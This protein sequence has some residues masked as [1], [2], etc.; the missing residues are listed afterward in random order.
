[1]SRR[2]AS[3]AGPAAIAAIVAISVW[4][5]RDH[6]R[7]DSFSSDEP[8]HLLAG[9]LQVFGHTAI[10]NMEHPPLA[11][12]LAG[13]ALTGLPLPPPPERVPLGWRF[14]EFGHA[15]LFQ[16]PVSPDV[17]AAR[18][19]LPFLLVLSGLLLV[20][21]F[22]ARRR[23][24]AAPALFA[25]ALVAFDPNIVAHAGIVHTDLPAT[26]TFVAAV[27][28]W[29][30][31]SRSPAPL[32]LAGVALVL[33]LALATKFSTIYLF[34]IFLI[35]G[36]VRLRR[37]QRPGREAVRL[38]ARLAVVG[39]AA[40]LVVLAVYAPVTARV[41]PEEQRGLIHEM[42]ADRGAPGISAAIERIS[43]FSRPLAHYLG[44]LAAVACQNAQGGGVN[45]LLGKTSVGGFPSYFVFALLFKS[46]LAFLVLAG[47]VVYALA[48]D[49]ASRR[50]A[51]LFL[52]PVVVLFVAAAGSSYNIGIRHLL[53]VYPFLALASAGVLA[54]ARERGRTRLAASLMIALP[55]LSAAELAHI[56]PHELSYFNAL[57]GGPIGGRRILSDS[58]VDWGVDLR[59][60]AAELSRRRVADPT[61]CYF[62]GDDVPYRIGVPDFAAEPLVRGRVVAISAF[63]LA[64]GPDYY[65][66]HGAPLIARAL[67]RLR[68]ELAARGRLIGR[69]GYSIDLYDLPPREA[70]AR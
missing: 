45:Y 66:Y 39:M 31:A 67:E 34:P 30:W 37:Q 10:V 9:Y 50:E 7:G 58:N 16:G 12:T 55:V 40:L 61:I 63:H 8:I 19:R 23:Y 56:H 1:M 2:A 62:G 15:F 29:D 3:L 54:R 70:A 46:T 48:R 69:V 5:V 14:N 24:G 6:T 26:L 27:L 44:G 36:L 25:A 17:I 13:L 21:F 49:P 11:K 68:Q 53:P 35:Q 51:P 38:L 20:V 28:A 65:A 32:R 60:L 47:R 59:R 57:A 22:S 41:I 43:R 18:A 33:G 42:V 4:L 52:L 64:L